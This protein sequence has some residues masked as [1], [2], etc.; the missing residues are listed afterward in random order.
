V[1]KESRLAG[2]FLSDILEPIFTGFA[3]TF[4]TYWL[5]CKQA[6]SL[7]LVDLA[8]FAFGF[9]ALVAGLLTIY[10]DNQESLKIIDRLIVRSS[11]RGDSALGNR[12]YFLNKP[13]SI[14]GS[15]K[16]GDVP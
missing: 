6:Y 10:R 1:D 11:V 2:T 14:G 12:N 16:S 5:L 7:R 8:S 13:Y 9:V 3:I 15:R 4:L